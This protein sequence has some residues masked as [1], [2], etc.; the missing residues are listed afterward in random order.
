MRLGPSVLHFFSTSVLYYRKCNPTSPA[1]FV[2]HYEEVGNAVQTDAH[3]GT[4]NLLCCWELR[5]PRLVAMV[6]NTI[7]VTPRTLSE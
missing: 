6:K 4:Y 1:T 3:K 7:F 5:L 2:I